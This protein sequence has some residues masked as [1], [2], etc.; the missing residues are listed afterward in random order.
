AQAHGATLHGKGPGQWGDLACFSFYPGK[1]LGAYGDAGAVVTN[2]AALAQTLAILKDHG[3][4]GKYESVLV[5]SNSRLDTLQAAVL[6]VKLPRLAQWNE[7]RRR[8]AHYYREQLSGLPIQLP[9]EREA[10]VPVYHL[11]VVRHGERDRLAAHLQEQGIA[12]GIHYP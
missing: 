2:D 3:R 11:F 6:L 9:V 7:A 4:T 12:S 8:W 10:S 5:G 1:N